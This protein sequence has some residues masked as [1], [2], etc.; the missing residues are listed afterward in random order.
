MLL[1][2]C[3]SIFQIMLVNVVL[4]GDNAMVIALAASSLPPGQRKQA[5]LWGTGLAV[6]LR[7]VLTFVVAYL[8]LIPGLRFLGAVLLAYIACKLIQ[9]ETDQEQDEYTAS[10]NLRTA[11]VRI[12]MADLI[13]S[14]DNV[15]AIAGV[16][17]ADPFRLFFG[18]ALSIALI[19]ALSTAIVALMARF[20]WIV[21]LGAAVLAL[22]AANMMAHDLETAHQFASAMSRHPVHVTQAVW[23]L[24]VVLVL[25]CL[26]SGY[27]WPRSRPDRDLDHPEGGSP[28]PA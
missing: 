4:S 3:S 14:F 1:D 16:A 19:L 20:R 26:T 21:Y 28:P 15:I 5:M 22:A 24:R 12:A 10:G 8:L 23:V 11:I 25:A 13:M 18:L 9:E 7:M 27:W 6:A 2:W 17:Q